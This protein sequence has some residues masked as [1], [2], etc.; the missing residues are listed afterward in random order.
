MDVIR[1]EL[2]DFIRAS[3][4]LLSPVSLREPLK[5]D[6]W[7]V[8]EFY[9]SSLVREHCKLPSDTSTTQQIV[10]KPNTPSV[11]VND[12]PLKHH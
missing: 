12:S 5:E 2:Q 4:T 7:Q 6:E 11:Q 1:K 9:A 8:I 3:E 10:E